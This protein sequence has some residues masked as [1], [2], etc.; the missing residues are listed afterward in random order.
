MGLIV[1]YLEAPHL[2]VFDAS[3][4]NPSVNRLRRLIDPF[5]ETLILI[6]LSGALWAG[7]VEH[8]HRASEIHDK[9]VCSA[10]EAGLKVIDLCD[11][12]E[13]SE[14][15]LAFHFENGGH[16]NNRGHWLAAQ[17]LLDM[18]GRK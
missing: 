7:N 13:A 16:W 8:R 2:F 6:I 3:V 9:L 11:S 12:M 5:D 17:V 1:P 4:I 10:R 18:I 14:I 15:P